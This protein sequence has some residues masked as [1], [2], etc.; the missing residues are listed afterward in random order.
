MPMFVD[1]KA[2][3][4]ARSGE[5][6]VYVRS[7]YT[8]REGME[9]DRLGKLAAEGDASAVEEILCMVIASWDGPAFACVPCDREHKA[10]LNMM[11]PLFGEIMSAFRNM[12]EQ[13]SPDPN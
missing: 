5:N 7:A 6:V 8:I 2:G 4:P 11:D 1:P 10:E 13:R 12:R 9:L 3:I